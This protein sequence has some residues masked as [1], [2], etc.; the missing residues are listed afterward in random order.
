MLSRLFY[1]CFDWFA[2]I[3]IWAISDES[4]IC[5]R[6]KIEAHFANK[7]PF[8]HYSRLIEIIHQRASI[9]LTHISV[10]IAL[11]VFVFSRYP[12]S[13][14]RVVILIE[15]ATYIVVTLLLIR[16]LRDFGLDEDFTRNSRL[17][18]E[19]L[20]NETAFR[21]SIIRFANLATIVATFAVFLSL[22]FS[23]AAISHNEIFYPGI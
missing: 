20:L 12:E 3:V 8:D 15:L 19:A 11:L 6:L 22:T 1:R 4:Q 9:L 14:G 5:K 7:K 23:P 10:M 18:S 13:V 17:Y 16:C 21:Y 2:R